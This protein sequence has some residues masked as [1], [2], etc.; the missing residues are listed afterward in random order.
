VEGRIWITCLV[1]NPFKLYVCYCCLE[2]A[3][4]IFSSFDAQRYEILYFQRHINHFFCTALRYND[5]K[6]ILKEICIN[7][8]P[9]KQ[10]ISL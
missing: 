1:I 3:V 10:C 5:E 6:C 8:E 9:A 4:F 7:F 2:R